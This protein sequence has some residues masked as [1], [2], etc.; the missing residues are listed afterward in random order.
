V[1]PSITVTVRVFA[2]PGSGSRQKSWLT[3]AVPSNRTGD[4]VAFGKYPERVTWRW[5]EPVA[6]GVKA[7]V[8]SM[9]V[10]AVLGG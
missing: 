7:K 6:A 10:V 1:A 5:K 4:V 9:P 2:V 8:P 3:V